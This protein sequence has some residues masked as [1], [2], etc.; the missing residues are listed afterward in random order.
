MPAR[1]IFIH[2]DTQPP[3]HRLG[4]YGCSEVTAALSFTLRTSLGRNTCVNCK[5]KVRFST[6]YLFRGA[7]L[8]SFFH[9]AINN[10]VNFHKTL[11]FHALK[12]QESQK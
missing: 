3:L 5:K 10:H 11:I 7:K 2:S 12:S 4:T 8:Q 6:Y 9:M 1:K